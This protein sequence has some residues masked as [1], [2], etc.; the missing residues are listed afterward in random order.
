M[1]KNIP[2]YA[3]SMNQ[4][5]KYF[6]RQLI[7]YDK[8]LDRLT[9]LSGGYDAYP[10]YNIE[11]I[12]DDKYRLSLALAGFSKSDISITKEGSVL[13]IDGDKK[14][15]EKSESEGFLYR[16][17]A[18]RAFSRQVQIAPDVEVDGATMDNGILHIDLVRII[19]ESEKPQTIK[20][21]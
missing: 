5:R 17:I 1:T 10:P 12:S 7:G 14:Q 19:P 21:K 15:S 20:I 6:E 4:A 3:Q 18:T 11:K 2:T 9:N 13:T 16:G 8:F